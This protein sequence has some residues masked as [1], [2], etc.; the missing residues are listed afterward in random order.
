VL[1]DRELDL[2]IAR[3]QGAAPAPRPEGVDRGQREQARAERQDRAVADR[4]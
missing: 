3:Q 2:G 4:L 1:K